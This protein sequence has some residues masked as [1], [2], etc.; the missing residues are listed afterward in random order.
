M[1]KALTP[2]EIEAVC[3][4]LKAKDLEYANKLDSLQASFLKTNPRIKNWMDFST[5]ENLKRA[6]V[7][8][9]QGKSV[10][11]T[12]GNETVTVRWED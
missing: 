5:V 6:M 9:H 4:K 10:S 7:G 12:K 2:E 8:L 11:V 3:E 1:A